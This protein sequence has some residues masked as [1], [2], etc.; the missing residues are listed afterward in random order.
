MSRGSDDSGDFILIDLNILS[1]YEE[2]VY[3][4]I[5][6]SKYVAKLRHYGRHEGKKASKKVIGKCN[7]EKNKK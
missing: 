3:S 5:Y 1:C 6:V 4:N 7:N 2:V